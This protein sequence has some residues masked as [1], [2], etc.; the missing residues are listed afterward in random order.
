M[1]ERYRLP[2]ALNHST[3]S[4]SIRSEIG[5]FSSCI[6]EVEGPARSG[7]PSR[8]FGFAQGKL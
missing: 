2:C 5:A 8:P 7:S 4:R 3:T 6:G 1:R